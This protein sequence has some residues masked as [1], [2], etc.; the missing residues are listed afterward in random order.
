MNRKLRRRTVAAACVLTST[1]LI[2]PGLTF[3][4]EEAE[5]EAGL[6]EW[7]QN[8]LRPLLDRLNAA[9]EGEL[10][11]ENPFEITV[12]FLKGSEGTIYVPFTMKMDPSVFTQ[13][14]FILYMFV[15]PHSEPVAADA[16]APASAED[17]F[18]TTTYEDLFFVDMSEGETVD[19]MLELRRAFQ[20]PG[21]TY[22]VYIV[23]RDSV[24]EDGDLDDL[25]DS[26][27]MLHKEEVEVPNFWSEEL[28]TS[29]IIMARSM[30]LIE[31]QLAP[32]DQ[33]INPYTIG[34]TRIVPKLNTN[35]TKS[36]NLSLLFYVY[37]PQ[38]TAEMNPDV[39]VEFD[40]YRVGPAGESFFNKTSPQEFNAQT[41][42]AGVPVTG[43]LPSG[44]SVPLGSFPAGDFR[45]EVKI[46][47]NAAGQMLTR[48]V[49]LN[50]SE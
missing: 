8:E 44:Q 3:A 23:V 2:N 45:L 13:S 33:R 29:S 47:D 1:L 18:R 10:P 5:V 37:N 40:F 19:E 11:A 42:P 15:T 43:G 14:Q 28:Q 41:W 48:D 39:T 32:E 16:D 50:V 38:L 17:T 4:Q 21:G 27:V 9:V 7:E 30:D 35:Y 25:D 31:A 24:G 22:D 20:A 12:D 46:I 34:T 6:E 49:L 36:D 26:M